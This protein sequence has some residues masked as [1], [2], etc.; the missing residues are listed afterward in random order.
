MT[1]INIILRAGHVVSRELRAIARDL[2]RKTET[3]ENWN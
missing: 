3:H 2:L 1:M